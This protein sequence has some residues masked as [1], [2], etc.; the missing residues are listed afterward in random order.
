[1][2]SRILCD[3]VRVAVEADSVGQLVSISLILVDLRYSFTPLRRWRVST[4]EQFNG[5]LFF[6]AVVLSLIG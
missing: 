1:M 5:F 4:D 6:I 3:D 2:K